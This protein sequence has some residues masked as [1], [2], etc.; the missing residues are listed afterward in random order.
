MSGADSKPALLREEGREQRL[1]RPHY[2]A[3]DLVLGALLY[4]VGL[5]LP[6]FV[7]D[8]LSV[9]LAHLE[10]TEAHLPLMPPKCQEL[11]LK[12][13]ATMLCPIV[14]GGLVLLCSPGRLT[15]RH[16]PASA[17]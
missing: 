11:E 17:S 13:C 8:T 14:F 10:R 9:A 1:A 6:L 16:P 12:V 2:Q 7:S 4:G 3:S 15:T 5:L